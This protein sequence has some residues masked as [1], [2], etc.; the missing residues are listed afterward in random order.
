M[1]NPVRRATWQGDEDPRICVEFE[2]L[3]GNSFST[4]KKIGDFGRQIMVQYP[5][6]SMNL[7]GV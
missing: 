2:R 3:T 4:P 5:N 6:C 7:D 1:G